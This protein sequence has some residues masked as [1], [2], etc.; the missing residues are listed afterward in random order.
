MCGDTFQQSMLML[1][2][3]F[4]HCLCKILRILTV[5]FKIICVLLCTIPSPLSLRK[6]AQKGEYYEQVGILLLK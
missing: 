2:L 6:I 4:I 3:R 1:L 5:T